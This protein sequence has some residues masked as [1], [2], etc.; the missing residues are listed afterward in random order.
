MSSGS[1]EAGTT[2]VVPLDVAGLCVGRDDAQQA[3]GRFAGATAVYTDQTTPTRD[4]FLGGN[5]NRNLADPPWDQLEEGVH[6]HWAL[7]DGLTRG[8]GPGHELDFPAVPDRWLVTRLSIEGGT[9]VAARSW[10]VHSD[11]L[12]AAPPPP[13]VSSVTLPV[14][15]TSQLPNTFAYLGH[16]YDITQGWVAERALG[17]PDIAQAAGVTLNAVSNGEVGFAAYYP[18]CRGVFGFHDA[19]EDMAPPGGRP[20]RLA[21]AVTGWYGDP[22]AD[23]VQPGTTPQQLQAARGWTFA[24]TGPAPHGSVY[25]GVLQGISWSPDVRYVAGRPVQRP[26]PARVA[27]GNTAA[28]ALSAYFTA[29]DRPDDPLFETLLNGFQY[30]LIES[31][32]QPS[33]GGL[34]R[35]R[36][37]VHDQRFAGGDGGTVY[38]IVATEGPRAGSGELID[39]PAPLADAL[40]RLNVLR[41]QADQCAFHADWYRWQMFADWYRIFEIAPDR[42]AEAYA[43]AAR[44]YGGWEALKARC[45]STAAAA[46]EQYELVN[47]M[48]F[49]DMRL[50]AGPACAFVQPSDPAVLITGDAV[51]FPARYGGDGRFTVEG[52]LVCRTGGDLLTS[53][54]VGDATLEAGALTGISAPA[55]LPRPELLTAL[56]REGCLLNTVLLAALTGRADADLRR[57]LRAAL[58]GTPQEACSFAGTPPSPVGVAWQPADQWLPVYAHWEIG[59]L[60]LAPTERG[61]E[62]VDYD[63]RVVNANY[64]LD[65]DAGGTFDYAPDGGKGSI[66]IDPARSGFPQSYTGTGNLTPT[67][68]AT[69]A[70]SLNG[71]LAS[72]ADRTLSDILAEL[73]G[74]AGFVVA[75]LNGLS[76]ALLQ[77]F[78]GIQLGVRVPAGSEYEELTRAMAPIIGAAPQAGG[79]DFNAPFNPLRAGY[80]TLK[81]TL[82]D[83]FG[84]KRTVDCGDMACAESMRTVAGGRPVPSVAQLSPRIAQPSRL[85]FRWLAAD[86]SGSEEMTGNPATTPVCGWLVPGHLDSSLAIYDQQSRALG[87]LSPTHGG[88]AEVAWQTAPGNTAGLGQD[89]ATAMAFQNPRLAQVALALGGPRATRAHFQAM[90]KL[91]DTV[92]ERVEP[93]PLTTDSDL[94][95]LVGRPVAI[96]AA[97]LRLELKGAAFLDLGWDRAGQD[98]DAA[99]TGVRFPVTVGDLAKLSDGLIGFYRQ[100]VP[101]GDYD[102]N[103]FYSQGAEA[104]STSRI[105]RPTQETLLLRPAPPLDPGGEH[106]PP[107]L[108]ALTQHVLMLVDPRA[109]VHATTGILPTAAL[110]LPPEQGQATASVLDLSLFAAPV[111]GGA[112]ELAIPVPAEAGYAVSYAEVGHDRQG[113]LNWVV[114]P[115]ITDPRGEAVWAYSPQEVRE[116]WLRLNPV[117]L[118]FVFADA[119]GRPL[120]HDGRPNDLTLTVINRAGRRVT[121]LPGAPVAEGEPPG[122]SVFFLHFGTLV[123]QDAVAR[124]S[125]T[126]PGWSFRTFS[127][128]EYGTY[129]AAAADAAVPLAPGERLQVAVTG[130]VPG[131]SAAQAQVRAGYHLV[132]GIDD[133]VWTGTLTVARAA[134]KP[135]R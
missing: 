88:P 27:V 38:S 79:P 68:A 14:R 62:P 46:Q 75:P 35:L 12:S 53:V 93:G 57:A 25:A 36:E 66:T 113:V 107:D 34:T 54:T 18:S 33:P 104:G 132:E 120:V 133:G 58:E 134:P 118:E 45:D 13:G 72:H 77:R 101:A 29:R 6:L 110:A 70:R 74:G 82:V 91:I 114:T 89:L 111:L 3:T 37:A 100:A 125:L 23:P 64:R 63:S 50:R 115:E 51:D 95:V 71:Y 94:S 78:P 1:A 127:S 9:P 69:L 19:L 24:A 42:Q 84:Q 20:A 126:A 49:P 10:L 26:L 55:G 73:T 59:Y 61:G 7:P 130:L 128:A 80:L 85:A 11:A 67:P 30:G 112:T 123:A 81:L 92:G 119:A 131:S 87:T 124:I 17:G 122:G 129:W 105:V 43:V 44:R 4:A 76:D 116:G 41:E 40:D 97:A 16:S 5:V 103:T 52:H 31:F 47:G 98:S 15:P 32:K 121:F 90:W 106:E 8:G 109:Q 83:V 65:Q 48:L 102:M 22:A 60:P 135:A 21:Y 108:A 117:V 86:G 99:L 2:L 28:E 56:L 96:V 39:L